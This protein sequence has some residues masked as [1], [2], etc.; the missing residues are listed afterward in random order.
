MRRS[1]GNKVL[2]LGAPVCVRRTRIFK[3]AKKPCLADYRWFGNV[4]KME[5]VG[6][7]SQPVVTGSDVE[8]MDDVLEVI[9]EFDDFDPGS[10]AVA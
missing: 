9:I 4:S 6:V 7:R 5:T 3:R 8:R 10:D 1:R 2:L